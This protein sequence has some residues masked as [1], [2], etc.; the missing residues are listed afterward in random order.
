RTHHRRRTDD[1][2]DVRAHRADMQFSDGMTAPFCDERL[3]WIGP[4]HVRLAIEGADCVRPQITAFRG[5]ESSRI[6]RYHSGF[7]GFTRGVTPSFALSHVYRYLR[8]LVF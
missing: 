7:G 1:R 6:E 4:C 3:A 5:V 2:V 8:N